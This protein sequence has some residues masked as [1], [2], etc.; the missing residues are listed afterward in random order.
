MGAALSAGAAGET[1]S[2]PGLRA[3]PRSGSPGGRGSQKASGPG[4]SAPGALA[5]GPHQSHPSE[6]THSPQAAGCTRD[7]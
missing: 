1:G 7:I 4:A 3:R 2:R 6:Q 5:P